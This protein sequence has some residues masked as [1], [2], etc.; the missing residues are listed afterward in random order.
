MRRACLRR[1]RGVAVVTALLLTTLAVTIVASLFWRQQVQIRSMENAR[2]QMQSKWV[3]RGMVDWARGVLSEDARVSAIDHLDE[4]WAFP[5]AQQA[6]ADYVDHAAADDKG[7]G[8]PRMAARIVDAQSRFN[9]GNLAQ[10]GIED[11]QQLAIFKRLLSLLQLDP[12]LANKAL[13]DVVATQNPEAAT[14]EGAPGAAPAAQPAPAKAAVHPGLK[15]L[16]DLLDDSAFTQSLVT[17]LKLYVT[18]LPVPTPVNVNTAGPEVLAAMMNKSVAEAA[19]LIAGRKSAFFKDE[20][21]FFNRAAI[22]PDLKL[23]SVRTDFFVLDA[24]VQYERGERDLQALIYRK[25]TGNTTV[26]WVREY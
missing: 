13:A 10:N 17:R 8:A 15:R 21:D 16:D 19:T 4:A 2:I 18:I 7:H 23:F 3:L 26:K 6:L 22:A 14:P 1:E 9:L 20:A 11:S 24:N 12:A 25:R 5:M